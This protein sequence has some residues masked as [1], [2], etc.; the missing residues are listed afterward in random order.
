MIHLHNRSL[1]LL[2]PLTSGK[3]GRSWKKLYYKTDFNGW[4]IESNMWGTEYKV[5]KGNKL[6]FSFEK[7]SDIAHSNYM[8]DLTDKKDE[9]IG[10]L[11]V[12]ALE[13]KKRS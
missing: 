8:V 3:D 4:V 7:T 6:V 11:I 12:L 5:T 10:L 9:L 13:A 2:K 1:G